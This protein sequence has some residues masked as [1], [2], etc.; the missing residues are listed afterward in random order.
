[1]LH[2]SYDT[3]S[4]STSSPK[5]SLVRREECHDLSELLVEGPATPSSVAHTSSC[6]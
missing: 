2:T 1:M 3:G 6:G 4:K 5:L